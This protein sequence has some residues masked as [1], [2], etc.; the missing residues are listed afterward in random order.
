[1]LH[2]FKRWAAYTSQD[3]KERTWQVSATAFTPTIEE[4]AGIYLSNPPSKQFL[5]LWNSGL[6]ILWLELME[7][8]RQTDLTNTRADGC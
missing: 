8:V 5:F 1:M 2:Q 3:I 7:C 4:R 6:R